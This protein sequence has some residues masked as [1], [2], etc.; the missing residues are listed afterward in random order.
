MLRL[1]AGQKRQSDAVTSQ[2]VLSSGLSQ[3]A[4]F[5]RV[6]RLQRGALYKFPHEQGRGGRSAGQTRCNA[7][8]V[9]CEAV[10]PGTQALMCLRPNNKLLEEIRLSTLRSNV[11]DWGWCSIPDTRLR[12]KRNVILKGDVISEDSRNQHGLLRMHWLA[13]VSAFRCDPS[14]LRVCRA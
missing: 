4:F 1:N 9:N 6:D 7:H 13:T 11:V 3:P 10:S 12:A 2:N 8:R 14:A 5:S